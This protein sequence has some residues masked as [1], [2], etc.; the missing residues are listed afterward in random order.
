MK[1][2]F[3]FLITLLLVAALI[4]SAVWYMFIYDRATVQDFLVGQA[5][6][7]AQNGK[8]DTAAWFYNLS[9]KLSGED[10]N[11]AIELA[12]IY[13]SVGNY[14]KAEHTLT[15]AI[16]DGG[17]AELYAALCRTYVEQ[18]KLLDAVN[19]LDNISDP[20][21]KAE[22][23]ARRPAAPTADFDS[24]FYNQYIDLTF[25]HDTG[26]LYVTT[27]GEYPSTGDEA[28][29]AP[30]TLTTG[31]TKIYALTVSED[32]LVSPLSILSYTVGG[33]VEQVTLTDPAIEGMIRQTLLFGQDTPIYTSDL[34]TITEFTVPAEA[35]ALEDLA[36]L[37]HLQQLTLVN[38]N[39]ESLDFLSTMSML[40]SLDLSGC[41]ISG[42]MAVLPTLPDLKKLSLAN[43][44]LSSIADLTGSPSLTTLDLSGNAIGDISP[45]GSLLSLQSI[46]LA[47]NAVTDLSALSGLNQLSSLDLS[48]NAVASLAPL[49]LCTG[50]TY[51]DVSNNKVTQVNAL[52]TLPSLTYFN[53]SH[54]AI[55]DVSAL[56]G[57][58]ELAYLYL[59]NNTLT[60]IS[61][62]SGMSKLL[63]LDFSHNSVT[64]LP[65]LP[66]G[67]PLVSVNGEYNLL[68]D[69][70][71][72]GA[73]QS[74]NYVFMDYNTELADISFLIN[75]TQLIQVNVY[76]TKVPTDMANALIDRSIIVNFDPT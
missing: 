5:R 59:D 37:T 2:T 22:L 53:A 68:T 3:K 56:A 48:H 61:A 47:N 9:Y 1:K 60:D 28:Y 4:G 26:T 76:G 58:T 63:E 54:N 34:W 40:Q 11:V 72:L 33:V 44:G 50:M 71:P 51:L 19:M 6:S 75:C 7:C 15:N 74:L 17:N 30:I 43:C 38:R 42:S 55:A 41:N 52:E 18:D 25:T 73:L 24:G 45:L 16:A 8:F 29:S 49:S 70:S 10:Q 46:N 21:I 27:N 20:V 13:K 65:A 69:I 14:T 31:E 35:T 36:H 57:C 66:S 39:V 67:C 64:I 12:D 32:G 23:D 62:I